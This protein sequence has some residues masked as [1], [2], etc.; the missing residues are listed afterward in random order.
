MRWRLRKRRRKKWERCLI[1]T[2]LGLLSL[3]TALPAESVSVC[4][5]RVDRNVSVCVPVSPP[6]CAGTAGH[7][8]PGSL[9]DERGGASRWQKVR[10]RWHWE[11]EPGHLGEDPQKPEAGSLKRKC[12]FGRWTFSFFFLDVISFR[13]NFLHLKHNCTL[14]ITGLISISGS[15]LCV[16]SSCAWHRVQSLALYRPLTASWRNSGKSTDHKV[17]RQVSTQM[18]TQIRSVLSIPDGEMWASYYR[19]VLQRD[20]KHRITICNKLSIYITTQNVNVN[21]DVWGKPYCYIIYYII[22]LHWLNAL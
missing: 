9:R 2:L 20:L 3:S 8:R 4:V 11:G 17:T 6:R 18:S 14:S 5:F 16:V 19:T 22:Y 1:C 13:C 21:I 10:G 7:R 12:S 15:N